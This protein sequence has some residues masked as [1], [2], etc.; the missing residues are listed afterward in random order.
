MNSPTPD[1]PPLAGDRFTMVRRLAYLATALS[2]GLIVLGGIVRITGS[3]MGCGDDWP[4]C[5]GEWFPPLDFATFIEIF[6]RWVAALVSVVVVATAAAAWWR[7]RSEPRVLWPATLGTVLLVTQVLLGAVTV[8][9]ELPPAVVIVHFTN[10]VLLITAVLVTGLR[11]RPA[12][13]TTTPADRHPTHGL[14]WTT[15]LVGFAAVLLGANVANLDAGP[16]CLGFPLCYGGVLPPSGTLGL[17]HWIHRIV[18]YGFLAL[19]FTLLVKTRKPAD[20]A[21]RNLRLAVAVAAGLAVIQIGIAAAMVLQL[22]PPGLRGFHLM[23]GTAIWGAL[24]VMVHHS[25]RPA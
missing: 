24:V 8:K 2:F 15:A 5:N 9:L 17:V 13:E 1:S 14:A 16:A 22:L 25:A 20:V 12:P 18:A 21:F 10:A 6:H 23:A 11:A 7:H 19:A 3:G 4:K